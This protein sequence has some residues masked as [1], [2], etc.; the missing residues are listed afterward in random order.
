[1]KTVRLTV[2]AL[3]LSG[4]GAHSAGLVQSVRDCDAAAA[5]VV[6]VDTGVGTFATRK[7]H[8]PELERV[9]SGEPGSREH[10]ARRAIDASYTPADSETSRP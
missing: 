9:L 10:Q 1:M 4:C 5:E 7:S 2:A 8:L 3:L 6:C